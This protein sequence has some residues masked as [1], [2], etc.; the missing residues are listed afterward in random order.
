[1]ECAALMLQI[2]NGP[3]SEQ[4]QA[5]AAVEES[6]RNYMPIRYV[7]DMLPTDERWDAVLSELL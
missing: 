5:S 7:M 4:V 3:Y 6:L 1:M 2:V